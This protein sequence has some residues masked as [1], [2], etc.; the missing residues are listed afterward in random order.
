MEYFYPQMGGMALVELLERKGYEVDIPEISVCCGLPAIHGGDGEGGRRS[1]QTNLAMM[2]NPD[3]YDAYIVLCPSCGFA[4]KDDFMHYMSDNPDMYKKA[5]KISA[6]VVSLANFLEDEG[7]VELTADDNRRVTYHTPPCHQ[8][9]GLGTGAEGLLKSLFGERF[10]PMTD[11]DVCCGF[12]GS[13]S[14]DFPGISKGIL[15]KK[16]ENIDAT[17]ADVVLTDCPGCVMQIRGGLDKYGRTQQVMHVSEL[18][19]SI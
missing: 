17:K 9:R 8:K 5:S 19:N 7:G 16:I 18:L 3:D 14:V 12:G 2:K 4:V 13:W 15:G 6:K 10:V 1:I 11:S